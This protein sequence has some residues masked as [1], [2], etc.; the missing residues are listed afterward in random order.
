MRRRT[1][2]IGLVAVSAGGLLAGCA[3]VERETLLASGATTSWS[4]HVSP[5]VDV[6]HCGTDPV[7]DSMIEPAVM[8]P[9][10]ISL[11][12]VE[13]ATEADAAR[14]ADCVEGL[15]S[16]GTISLQPPACARAESNLDVFACP[17]DIAS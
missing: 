14:V 11:V 15:M 4:V 8:P 17:E 7:L 5:H 16:D 3:G 1:L 9:M 2:A 10:S 6:R 13:S 12:L